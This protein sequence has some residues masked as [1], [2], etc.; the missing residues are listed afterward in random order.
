M[1]EGPAV[2]VDEDAIKRGLKRER[3]HRR[4]TTRDA[5]KSGGGGVPRTEA[6]LRNAPAHIPPSEYEVWTSVG[7]ALKVTSVITAKG[8]IDESFDSYSL[9]LERSQGLL[10]AISPRAANFGSADECASKWRTFAAEPRFGTLSVG[11]IL[12][13]AREGGYKG[14]TRPP[15]DVFARLLLNEPDLAEDMAFED[16]PLAATLELNGRYAFIVAA[17][18]PAASRT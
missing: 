6:I 4:A 7:M 17:P 15:A 11:Y 14:L 2:E 5:L 3:K 13:R 9:W 1:Q 10:N 16:P 12:A 18:M 8:R